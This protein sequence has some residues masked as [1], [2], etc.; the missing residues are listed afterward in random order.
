MWCD[1]IAPPRERKIFPVCSALFTSCAGSSSVQPGPCTGCPAQG[2]GSG[3]TAGCRVVACGTAPTAAG[4]RA[5]PSAASASTAGCSATLRREECAVGLL[6]TAP[7]PEAPG[8]TR[9][10]GCADRRGARLTRRETPSPAC[11]RH[12]ASAA[13]NENF[14]LK[15]FP[16]LCV[17]E[18][19]NW[20][21]SINF[22][23]L[24]SDASK[25]REFFFNF[26]FIV[27][28]AKF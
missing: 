12:V 1:K 9:A 4:A 20:L 25:F 8:T 2:R 10:A 27:L 21:I 22:Y 19:V 11:P 17:G 15:I 13:F 23:T 5:W 7:P 24:S 14:Q 3:N 28:I 16:E 26:K 6:G 18:L